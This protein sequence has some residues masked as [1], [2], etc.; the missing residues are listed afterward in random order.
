MLPR[1]ASRSVMLSSA[2]VFAAFAANAEPAP[3]ARIEV[4]QY[5]G[6]R[7]PADMEDYGGPASRQDEAGLSVRVDHLESQLRSLTGQLEQAQ[8]QVRKL[9][10]Q[11]TKFQQDVEFR[12]QESGHSP[13]TRGGAQRR[14]ELE[15]TPSTIPQPQIAGATPGNSGS[16]ATAGMRRGDAFDPAGDPNAPGVPRQL[17]SISSSAVAP[18]PSITRQAHADVPTD[19][20]FEESRDPRQPG[21]LMRRGGATEARSPS[22]P[23]VVTTERPTSP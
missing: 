9:Q 5:Y 17:G 7:P 14:S 18:S 23:L 6:Q 3:S 1:F 10:E 11:L 15:P 19:Q 2:F 13:S 16:L 21:D 22:A 12:F 20:G 4:A 8:F